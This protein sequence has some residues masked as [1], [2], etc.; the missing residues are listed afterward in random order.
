LLDR[1]DMLSRVRP[2]TPDE[3]LQLERAVRPLMRR[4]E[5]WHWTRSDDRRLARYL[6]RGR[7]PKMIAILMKRTERA[8]WQRMMRL[9][10]RVRQFEAATVQSPD[11]A[12]RGK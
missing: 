6:A 10:L 5:V 3:V 9:G 4:N 12:E 2:L 7:K 1:L 8:V 11:G